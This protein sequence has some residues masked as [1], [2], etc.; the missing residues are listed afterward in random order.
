M[1]RHWT[2]E[3]RHRPP[4]VHTHTHTPTESPIHTHSVNNILVIHSAT[5]RHA[6]MTSEKCTSFIEGLRHLGEYS[7]VGE[8]LHGFVQSYL[9]MSFCG[10][11]DHHSAQPA[12]TDG[13]SFRRESGGWCRGRVRANGALLPRGQVVTPPS[14]GWA[15]IPW[16]YWDRDCRQRGRAASKR[17]IPHPQTRS[18]GSEDT[19]INA[20]VPS[21]L[22]RLPLEYP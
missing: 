20:G 1:H 4:R 19:I 3:P 5:Q 12:H 16:K 9:R 7:G 14:V 15:G 8:A 18:T 22:T 17:L 13:W 10:S 2:L 21:E 11:S 6:S